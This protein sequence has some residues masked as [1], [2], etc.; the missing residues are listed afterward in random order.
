MRKKTLLTIAGILFVA[1][2]AA[3]ECSMSM[4]TYRRLSA[5]EDL[6]A[7]NEF[8]QAE[9]KLNEMLDHLPGRKEDCAYIYYTTAM[10]Y[11][12]KNDYPKARSYFESAYG[13]QRF[14][15]KTLLYVEKTLAGLYMQEENFE[16][17]IRYYEAHMQ[18]APEPDKDIYLGL[19]TAHYYRKAYAKAIDL[20]K[21][22]NALFEPSP[23]PFLMLFSSYYELQRLD[24]AARTLE[25]MIRLWPDEPRYWLQLATLYIERGS[26]DRSLEIMQAA[27]TR[28]FL[29]KETDIMQYV[30]ALYE[31]HLPYK[32]ATIL[33][34]AIDLRFLEENRKNYE[35]LAT[36]FHEAKERESAIQGW[37]KAADYSTDGKNDLCIAQLC[38]EMEDAYD[39]VIRYANRALAKGIN[40]PGSA[41]MLI[42][43]ACN[44]LGQTDTA[45]KHIMEAGRYKETSKTSSQWLKRLDDESSLLD[46]AGNQ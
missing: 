19:G 38:F 17:A 4:P 20:F 25:Q 45:K 14:P 41:H 11:L 30:Y 37:E 31:E 2:Q 43:V 21:K 44:E 1:A 32:A 34:R 12:Q 9:A 29:T 3:A 23:S 24:E 28:E 22:A 18:H 26:Y 13:L 35:M 8:D 16:S 46:Y 7:E 36:M 42:A 39:R 33:Q 10:L 15:Q 5:I 6:M 40:K 27:W